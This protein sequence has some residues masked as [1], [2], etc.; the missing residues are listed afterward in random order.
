MTEWNHDISAAPRT[1]SHILMATTDGKRYLT[2]WLAPTK[3]TPSGRFDGFSE[4]AKTLLAWASVPEHPNFRA[5][6]GEEATST[7]SAASSDPV[8]RADDVRERQHASTVEF[9]DDCRQGGNEQAAAASVPDF[10]LEDCGS[11]A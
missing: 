9:T 5:N 10:I 4:N 8:S 11:G 1:G 3:F 2:R 7:M 6:A